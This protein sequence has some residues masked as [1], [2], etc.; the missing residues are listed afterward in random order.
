M[1]REDCEFHGTRRDVRVTPTPGRMASPSV[2]PLLEPLRHL[3]SRALVQRLHDARQP[4]LPVAHEGGG[5]ALVADAPRSADSVHVVVPTSG[6]VKIDDVVDARQVQPARSDL[7]G[8]Q[9]LGPPTLDLDDGLVAVPLHLVAVDPDGAK[10]GVAV[11]VVNNVVDS[12]L[13]VRE[14]DGLRL[15]VC[16]GDRLQRG[17]QLLELVSPAD[18]LEPLLH[19]GRRNA[20]PADVDLHVDRVQEVQGHVLHVLGE[21]GGEHDRLPPALPGLGHAKVLDDLADLRLE[22]HV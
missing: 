9:H 14:H 16:P 12:G 5:D 17:D 2:G 11:D 19:V 22:T 13:H 10:I 4:G 1:R 6:Q 20:D 8:D 15:A 7:C 18:V 21:G 3:G